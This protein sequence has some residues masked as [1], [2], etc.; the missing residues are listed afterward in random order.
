[1][2]NNG[3]TT[4]NTGGTETAYLSEHSSSFPC[5]W[6]LVL[7]FGALEFIPTLLGSCCPIFSFLCR[8]CVDN[9]LLSCHFFPLHNLS[10]MEFFITPLV[11]IQTFLA[12]S[13]FYPRASI[14]II[15]LINY[16]FDLIISIFVSNVT[17]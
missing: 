6:V 4:G 15:H 14:N 8:V 5:C 16:M 17:F 3:N 13:C 1:M 10:F 7:P 2:F 12:V 9:C 11:Y